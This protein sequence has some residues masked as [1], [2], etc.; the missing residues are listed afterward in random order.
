[1]EDI[2]ETGQGQAGV[3]AGVEFRMLG[4]CP[5][6]CVPLSHGEPIPIQVESLELS[7]LGQERNALWRTAVVQIVS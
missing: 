1:M 2:N 4:Q 7:T 3:L 5:S 6:K